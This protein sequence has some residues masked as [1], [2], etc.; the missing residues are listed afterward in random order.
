M[1]SLLPPSIRLTVPLILFG[2]VLALSALY[3]LYQVPRAEAAV[4]AEHGERVLQE[5]S[6]LRSTLEY[7]LGKE[8]IDGV[9]REVTKLASNRNNIFVVMTDDHDV[10]NAATDRTWLGR[11]ASEVLPKSVRLQAKNVTQADGLQVVRE[12]DA[13]HH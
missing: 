13:R 9:R 11:P 10:V 1:K 5:M 2:F 7:L 12:R 3:L 4:E 8:D 6:R